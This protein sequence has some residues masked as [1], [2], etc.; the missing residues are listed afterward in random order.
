LTKEADVNFDVE[1]TEKDK[2]VNGLFKVS[3]FRSL[4]LSRCLTKRGLRKINLFSFSQS[5]F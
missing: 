4:K 2:T 1:L 3:H 5:P